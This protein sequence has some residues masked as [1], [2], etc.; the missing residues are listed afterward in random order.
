MR[1]TWPVTAVTLVLLVAHGSASAAERRPWVTLTDCRYMAAKDNDGDSF[2]VRCGS[3]DFH[4]RLYFVDAP[5]T[6]LRYAER[7]REQSEHFGVTLDETMK[8]GARARD[9]VQGMLREPFVVRTR[10]ATA[11]GRGREPRYYALVEVGGRS[12]VEVLVSRGLARPKGVSLA[13]PTGEK[14]RAYV[15]RLEALER[16]AR[17]KRLGIWA[18]STDATTDSPTR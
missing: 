7:T 4:L 8:A 17:Q 2:R 12:L 10:W 14:A 16:D 5:E 11:G 18:T 3:R 9:T 15:E 13:L 1:R 6:N